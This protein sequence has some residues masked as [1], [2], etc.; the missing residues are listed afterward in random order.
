MNFAAFDWLF[1]GLHLHDLI[2]CALIGRRDMQTSGHQLLQ[3][4]HTLAVLYSFFIGKNVHN[5]KL[6]L[7]L[8]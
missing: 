4:L 1:V 6:T 2:M 7:K 3:I 8:I 5:C